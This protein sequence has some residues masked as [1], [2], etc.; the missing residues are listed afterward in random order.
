MIFNIVFL[1]RVRDTNKDLEKEHGYLNAELSKLQLSES[2]SEENDAL[3]TRNQELEDKLKETSEEL[4]ATQE[5]LQSHDQAAKRA[6]AALQKEMALRV[7]QVG[8]SNYEWETFIL[9][10]W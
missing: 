9:Y 8:K 6:I 10:H 4:V 5:K 3:K 2:K 7:D 1:L